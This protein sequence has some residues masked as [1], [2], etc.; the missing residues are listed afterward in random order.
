M[1]QCASPT[2]IGSFRTH[3]SEMFGELG[4]GLL[5]VPLKVDV[6]FAVPRDD[7]QTRYIGREILCWMDI[8][9]YISPRSTN[10]RSEGIPALELRANR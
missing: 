5:H 7:L 3:L 1:C 2:V 10:I 8:L 4:E 6:A 9:P